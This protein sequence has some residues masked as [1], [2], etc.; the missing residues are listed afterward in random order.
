MNQLAILGPGLLGGSLAKAIRARVPQCRVTLWVR[1]AEAVEEARDAGVADFVSQDLAAVVAE[2]DMVVLCMPVEAMPEI[3]ARVAPL[4]SPRAV[5]T[6][7]GSVKGCVV[8][9]LVPIF[10]KRGRFVGSHPMAGSE[11][12]GLSAARSDL[13]EGAVCI[14]TP[15]TG[16]DP[17][18]VAETCRL[19]ERVGCSISTLSPEEHDRAVG[20]VSHL[21][22][23]LAAAL[24]D[25]VCAE[26]PES[27]NFCGNG[28]RDT[29]RVA[30]GPAA[31]WTGIFAA[32]RAVVVGQL[33]RMIGRLQA[34]S[35]DLAAGNDTRIYEFLANAKEA[36]DRL[37]R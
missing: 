30:A 34:I 37:N 18:A 22:H 25:F 17:E 5:V 7:V 31:M 13:Y 4:I 8:D 19:W 28:F 1:R 24:V 3:A 14:V 26:S 35:K 10:R 29:T 9:A 6:D 15:H 20:L 36:R 23:L 33:D 16:A 21:P 12:S 27:V 2:A 32:N 11:Q